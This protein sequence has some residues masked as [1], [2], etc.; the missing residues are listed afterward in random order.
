[1]VG[2]SFQVIKFEVGDGR[3]VHFW[4][5]LWCGNCTLNGLFPEVVGPHCLIFG[6][7]TRGSMPLKS[8][9]C[10]HLEDYEFKLFAAF[11]DLYEPFLPLRPTESQLITHYFNVCLF[12]F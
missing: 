8:K 1:M 4:Q 12:S 3:W 9:L 7:F 5:D 2:I 6:K 11:T 10:V